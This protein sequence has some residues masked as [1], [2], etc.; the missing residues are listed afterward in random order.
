MRYQYEIW[1]RD[2]NSPVLY[3]TCNTLAETGSYL[4]LSVNQVRERMSWSRNVLGNAWH[5]KFG[6]FAYQILR[7]AIHK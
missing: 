1:T 6:G 2:G 7:K 3:Q 5:V 4:D